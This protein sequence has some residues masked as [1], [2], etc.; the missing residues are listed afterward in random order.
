MFSVDVLDHDDW[1]AGK[2]ADNISSLRSV[3]L[4]DSLESGA[5]DYFGLEK[6]FTEALSFGIPMTVLVIRVENYSELEQQSAS[7]TDF[8]HQVAAHL[9][10]GFGEDSCAAALGGDEFVLMLRGV[11]HYPEILRIHNYAQV[12]LGE[13]RSDMALSG[14]AFKAGVARCPLDDECLRTL[15]VLAGRAVDELE[16]NAS[17]LQFVD[18]RHR[19]SLCYRR[20]TTKK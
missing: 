15:L 7:S 13:S 4:V 6:A 5:I 17:D 14:F 9:C 3:G 11:H 1:L 8:N 2:Q 10:S 18:R 16:G 20:M 19:R 12:R